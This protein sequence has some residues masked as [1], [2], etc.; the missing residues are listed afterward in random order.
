MS[1]AWTDLGHGGKH[2]SVVLAADGE[3]MSVPAIAMQLGDLAPSIPGLVRHALF[4]K[5]ISCRDPILQGWYQVRAA[6][7]WSCGSECCRTGPESDPTYW[8]RMSFKDEPKTPGSETEVSSEAPSATKPLGNQATACL[9]PQPD[10]AQLSSPLGPDNV[11]SDGAASA[12]KASIADDEKGSPSDRP[13][14]A[15]RWVHTPTGPIPTFSGY[16]S[17][18]TENSPIHTFTPS[19]P[20]KKARVGSGSSSELGNAP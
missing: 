11:S 19:P 8:Q 10:F 7:D 12:A 5:D 3:K 9:F 18:V 17:G 2:R 20:S 16:G 1:S 4:N 15:P 13:P 6:F 14:H